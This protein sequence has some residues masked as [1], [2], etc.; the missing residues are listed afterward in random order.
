MFLK[1][2]FSKQSLLKVM[3]NSTKQNSILV[4][5]IERLPTT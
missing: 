2:L 4:T 3:F 1:T 5:K